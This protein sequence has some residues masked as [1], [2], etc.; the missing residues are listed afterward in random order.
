MEKR[1]IKVLKR[2][3]QTADTQEISATGE[4]ETKVRVNKDIDDIVGEWV[5]QRRENRRREHKESGNTIRGWRLDQRRQDGSGTV[6]TLELL[7]VVIGR[8]EKP[9][10]K[11]TSG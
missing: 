1:P 6:D 3:R 2:D 5:V 10:Q 7:S 11:R 8:N 9:L 4:Q